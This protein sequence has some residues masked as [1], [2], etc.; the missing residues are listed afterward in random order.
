VIKN[1]C[2]PVSLVLFVAIGAF[3]ICAVSAQAAS[4]PSASAAASSNAV[5]AAV[6]SVQPA[7]SGLFQVHTPRV[8]ADA[9][10]ESGEPGANGV[11]DFLDSSQHSAPV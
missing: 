7:V 1:R 3:L 4:G 6:R 2:S 10:D 5:T 8:W 9:I 11:P